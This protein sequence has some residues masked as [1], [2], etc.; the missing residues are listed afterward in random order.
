MEMDG[1]TK[2]YVDRVCVNASGRKCQHGT[3]EHYS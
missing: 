1:M 3:V 2:E